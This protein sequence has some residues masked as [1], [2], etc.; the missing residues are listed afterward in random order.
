MRIDTDMETAIVGGAL[1]VMLG[2]I[3]SIG[4]FVLLRFWT[5]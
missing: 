2:T 4:L 5:I 3:V 1:I